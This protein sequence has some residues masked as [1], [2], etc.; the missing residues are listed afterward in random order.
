MKTLNQFALGYADSDYTFKM[1]AN[2]VFTHSVD[3]KTR[4]RRK[5]LFRKASEYCSECFADIQMIIRLKKTGEVYILTSKSE[6]WP[7][8]KTQLV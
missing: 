5:T 3:Q 1:N 2:P 8:S 7:L 4:R 6:G